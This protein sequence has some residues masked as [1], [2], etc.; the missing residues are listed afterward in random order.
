MF[1]NFQNVQIRREVR[2]APTTYN[3]INNVHEEEKKEDEEIK[4]EDPIPWSLTGVI[5]NNPI[6]NFLKYCVGTVWS[7]LVWFTKLIIPGGDVA[8]ETNGDQFKQSFEAKLREYHLH[9]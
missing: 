8:V 4:Q 2:A 7:G 1:G 5:F 3:F 9:E 6:S